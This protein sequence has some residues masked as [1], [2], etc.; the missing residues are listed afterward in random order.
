MNKH[1]Q[2]RLLKEVIAQPSKLKHLDLKVYYSNLEASGQ[3]SFSKIVDLIIQELQH[4]F[5]DPREYRDPN[6]TNISNERLFYMLIDESPR[7]FKKGMIITATVSRVLDSKA[8][9]RL[10]NGLSAIIHA[11]YFLL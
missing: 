10:D 4:P 2:T 1:E 3:S 6:K 11:N 5:A 8:I 9:C 7:T